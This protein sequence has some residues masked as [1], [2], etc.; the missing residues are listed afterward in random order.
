[1]EAAKSSETSASY[2]NITRRHNTEDLDFNLH[3]REDLKYGISKFV[4]GVFYADNA[5]NDDALYAALMSHDF[6]T[7]QGPIQTL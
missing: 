3:R 1:M 5:D 6:F 2:H 4:N 7:M